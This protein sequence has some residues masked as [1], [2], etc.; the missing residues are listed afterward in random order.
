MGYPGRD[1]RQ[2]GEDFFRLKKG[3]EDFFQTYFS[4]NPA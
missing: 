2:G 4:Q 3:S 1:R